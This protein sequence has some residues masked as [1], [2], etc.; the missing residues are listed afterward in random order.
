MNMQLFAT[1]GYAVF[2]PDAPQKL[3]T[4]MFDLAKTILPGVNKI[5]EMGIADPERLGVMG[6]SYGGYSTLALIV[7]TNRFK[8][9]IAAD[10]FADVISAYGEMGPHGETFGVSS[11]EHG[12]GLMGSSP[13]EYRERYEENSPFLYLDR[14]Q[15]PTLL[16]QGSA[17]EVTAPFL[18]DQVFVGLR[19]LNKV[20]EYAKYENEKHSPLAWSYANQVDLLNRTIAWF[21]RYLMSGHAPAQEAD[22]GFPA[23]AAPR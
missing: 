9:A 10:G 2:L 16:V 18:G 3:G 14:V 20:V 13:W 6:H 15:T 19:R 11:S 22:H 21:N 23:P 12:Q 8:A 5:I 4:P 17:D 7:Q 1:R